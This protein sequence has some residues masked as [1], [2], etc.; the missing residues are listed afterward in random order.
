[1]LSELNAHVQH[2]AGEL[3]NSF[4]C[5]E[6]CWQLLMFMVAVVTLAM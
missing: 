3:G 1:M 2:P 6:K 4:V 5:A